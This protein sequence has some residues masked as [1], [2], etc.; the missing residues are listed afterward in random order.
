[1][2][3]ILKADDKA[4][5]ESIAKASDK[6]VKE[7]IVK[8]DK[9]EIKKAK[10]VKESVVSNDIRYKDYKE[11]LLD[12]KTYRHGMDVLRSEHHIIF[13]QHLNKISFSPF[14]S[15]RWIAEDGVETLAYGHEEIAARDA[16]VMDAFIDKL[17]GGD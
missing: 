11:A 8:A 17:V 3:A 4:V 2:Y 9:K 16:A 12:K 10:G 14:D 6:D 1:M 13:G 7:S 5:E 15:K